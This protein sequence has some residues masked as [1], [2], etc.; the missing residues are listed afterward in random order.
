MYEKLIFLHA[1]IYA[2]VSCDSYVLFLSNVLHMND[3]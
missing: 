2:A 3:I 1:P